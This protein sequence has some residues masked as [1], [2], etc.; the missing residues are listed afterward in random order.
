MSS[1][2]N[3]NY[4]D[5]IVAMEPDTKTNETSSSVDSQAGTNKDSTLQNGF[6]RRNSSGKRFHSSSEELNSSEIIDLWTWGSRPSREQLHDCLGLLCREQQRLCGNASGTTLY[7][8]RFR[9]RATVLK[10]YFIAQCRSER[11]LSSSR[12]AGTEEPTLHENVEQSVEEVRQAP[13]DR[14]SHGLARLGS[15]AALSFAFAFLRRAWRSGEDSDLCTELLQETLDA[16]IMLPEAS[17]FDA[18]QVS[19]VWLEVVERTSKFLRSVVMG[20]VV[21][22]GTA[23]ATTVAEIP[24]KDRHTALNLLL[25]FAVQKGSLH[26]M[27]DMV[28][29][30]ISIWRLG[31]QRQDNRSGFTGPKVDSSAPLIHFLKRFE[32]IQPTKIVERPASAAVASDN[33]DDDDDDYVELVS[34]TEAFLQYLEYPENEDCDVDLQQAAVVI[35]S[36]LD[37]LAT[38]HQPPISLEFDFEDQQKRQSIIWA[39]QLSWNIFMDRS[40]GDEG[41]FGTA[42][43]FG[44]LRIKQVVPTIRGLAGLSH[45]G[46]LFYFSYEA[47]QKVIQFAKVDFVFS[48][49]H[50]SQDGKSL[51]GYDPYQASLVHWEFGLGHVSF[52]TP[53]DV[54]RLRDSLNVIKVVAGSGHFILLTQSGG[55]YT[56]SIGSAGTCGGTLSRLSTPFDDTSLT[57]PTIVTSLKGV[58]ITDIACGGCPSTGDAFCLALC[59]KGSVYTWGDGDFGK[60]GRGGSDSTKTPRIVDKL[61]GLQVDKIFCGG[62]F[63]MALCRN[64]ALYSWGQGDHFRLGHGTEEHARLP[65]FVEALL[66]KKIVHVAPG[67]S[68]VMIVTDDR[69]VI[70]WGSNE[71]GHFGTNNSTMLTHPTLVAKLEMDLSGVCLGPAQTVAWTRI[72]NL[73]T[74]VD[75]KIPFVLDVCEETFRCLDQLLD[76]VWDGLDG[77]R[78]WPPPKQ[79][80]ECIAVSCLNLL[81]LQLHALLNHKIK[82]NCLQQGTTL[83]NSLKTKVIELASNNNVL[84]TIQ[85]SAQ[86]CLQ[87]GWMLLLPTAEE[88]ARALST[89]LPN[90]SSLDSQGS[91]PQG[92]RFMTDLLTSSLMADGGLATALM[93]AIKIEVHDIEDTLFEKGNEQD[94]PVDGCNLTTTEDALM[95]EQAQMEAESKRCHHLC[96]GESKASTIPLLLLVKQ[97]L[98]NAGLQTAS[99]LRELTLERDNSNLNL[100]LRFQRLLFVQLFTEI[101]EFSSEVEMTSKEDGDSS[102]KVSLL[103]KYMILL[104]NHVMEVV[105]L[106][107]SVAS[108]SPQHFVQACTILQ[109]DVVGLLLPEFIMS[110]TLLHLEDEQLMVTSQMS[111]L[112]LWLQTLDHFNNLAPG[113]NKEDL[114]DMTWP[115]TAKY[116]SKGSNKAGGNNGGES[117]MAAF[118]VPLIRKADLENHNKDGGQWIVVRGQ[119]YDLEDFRSASG[120]ASECAE[121]VT[122][123]FEAAASQGDDPMMQSFY[124]GNLCEPSDF[125]QFQPDTNTQRE[126]VNFSSP[127]IDMERNLALFLGLFNH[128]LYK[129]LP[130][131]P[132]EIKSMKWTSISVGLLSGGLVSEA[133]LNTVNEEKVEPVASSPVGEEA[134]EVEHDDPMVTS[135]L[136]ETLIAMLI[137]NRLQDQRLK[138]FLGLIER[139]CRQ[140]HLIIHLNFP[141]DHPV[142]EVGRVLLAVLIKYQGLE[143]LVSK[144]VE[145]EIESPGENSG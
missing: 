122:K 130:L 118:D 31:R 127:F 20:D 138:V 49:I 62:Q 57:M 32:F 84:E 141:Q 14:G 97:L 47:D 137:E 77:R 53:L 16:L 27:L 64:G 144:M 11:L 106:A 12:M 110:L 100:L 96:P 65:K 58:H 25:E 1:V 10:R 86:A 39:G 4:Y 142:E 90:S 101:R 128:S 125:P 2:L 82:V 75:E 43:L 44:S 81:K 36:H 115:G 37:R 26:E 56:W 3:K 55:V 66:G 74:S 9:Q 79:D 93:A 87:V 114:D 42:N 72:P 133:P 76:E 113:V 46:K 132:E 126:W 8:Y 38:P 73:D 120:P 45:E 24:A 83:L 29:L 121:D 61:Q 13:R 123:M 124:V 50:A 7:S 117:G 15:R 91:I 112:P 19:S 63:A 54:L 95:T 108:E 40:L 17:L 131:E 99:N 109:K 140:Q 85:M 52:D 70:A 107:I 21:S 51:V 111:L 94:K 88:R 33:D 68:N 34:A 69:Q 41:N 89:L 28:K 30:L 104:S 60:L 136:N 103:K 105:P 78:E 116:H 67:L 129:S 134:P 145:D 59:D 48:H 119:V 139:L 5:P 18:N 98:K 6:R 71:Y 80:Q 102:G 35:M 23:S 22:Q 135:S 92:K 143:N